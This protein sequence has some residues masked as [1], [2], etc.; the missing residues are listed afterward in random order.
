[1][2]LVR[3]GTRTP[4]GTPTIMHNSHRPLPH[5]SPVGQVGPTWVCLLV[6]SQSL[7]TSGSA[8]ISAVDLPQKL[9]HIPP[10]ATGTNHDMP[11]AAPRIPALPLP[12]APHDRK[13]PI[14]AHALNRA[15]KGMGAK[16]HDTVAVHARHVASTCTAAESR[17]NGKTWLRLAQPS[18]R[19]LPA[20][21]LDWP[22]TAGTDHCSPTCTKN[23][24]K[25]PHF[26]L[27]AHTITILA[28]RRCHCA[29]GH[30]W[31]VIKVKGLQSDMSAPAHRLAVHMSTAIPRART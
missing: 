23:W 1:V 30:R 17:L 15:S 18:Y 6:H 8:T 27:A 26:P 22:V 29:I 20:R 31:V 7:E 10:K 9:P 28:T 3:L 14:R 16:C 19:A 21:A 5:S 2:T 25:A 4:A 11:H 24:L 13:L 12:L